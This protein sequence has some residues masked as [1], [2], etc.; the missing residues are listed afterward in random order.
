MYPHNRQLVSIMRLQFKTQHLALL[1]ILV[2][3]LLLRLALW[4]RLPRTGMISDE[5][6]YLAAADWLANGR[7]FAWHLGWLW[8]RAPLYPIFIATHLVAFGQN[9]APIFV[10]Q[11]LLSLLNIGLVYLLAGQLQPTSNNARWI[12]ALLAALYLP[13]A[14]YT[15]LLLSETLFTTLMLVAFVLLGWGM[16]RFALTGQDGG[17]PVMGQDTAGCVPTVRLRPLTIVFLVL[18]GVFF[19]L[20]TLTRGLMLGFLPLVGLWLGWLVWQRSRRWGPALLVAACLLL[21]AALII[22]PWTL[23]ASRVYGGLVIVDTTG[24]FNLLLGARTAFDGGRNDEPV[25]SFVQALLDPQLT[26]EQRE[27]LLGERR[28]RDGDLL[29]RGACLYERRDPTLL[30]ALQHDVASITQAERQRLMTA[31]AL[32]LL[33]ATPGAFASKSLI[34]LIDL[35]QIN[36]TGD[37]RLASGFALGRL[38]A[39]YALSLFL[40]DDT[41]YV[42]VLPLAVLGWALMGLQH[43]GSLYSPARAIGYLLGLWLLYNLAT[44]P[45]L[46]AINRFRVPLMPFV[47]VFAAYA[48]AMLPTGGW[49]GLRSRYGLACGL[50]AGLLGLIALSPHAYLEPLRPGEGSR[51][52][53]YLGPYPS[54]LAATSLALRSR[55]AYQREQELAAALAQRDPTLAGAA[56]AAPE[57]PSYAAALGGPLL[58]GLRGAPAAGLERLATQ[59]VQPLE[60][61]QR[62]LV[63]G[64]LLRQMGQIEAARAEFGPTEVDI[65]NP[66]EWAWQ[67]LAPPPLA[68]NRLE[69]AEDNDLGYLRGFYLGRFDPDLQATLRWATDGAQLRFP[70]AGSGTPQQL[71]LHLTGLGW[72]GDL[73]MPAVRVFAGEALLGT[74]QL[75]AQLVTHCLDLPA[76]PAGSEVVTLRAPTF[77]PP[78]ADLLA[79]QGPQ[80]GQLRRLA[81]QL[82]WAAIQ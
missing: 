12:A 2:V 52:A 70:A 67:W 64:E 10:S 61:W 51:L 28:G 18:A 15:Q 80:V 34:E 35:F 46:F 57:L 8:T 24:A 69:V 36:Y 54:S 50:L 59:I 53:S 49:R 76:T 31:E 42:F 5:A 55:P 19:G 37:E 71:C 44:A 3:A 39:W 23:Y 78:A 26:V 60:D 13:F 30:A 77:V 29:R 38:P 68:N 66:V 22:A 62:S 7:G 14:T 79:Q 65:E 81:L 16:G 56:M 45:L 1:L 40:L 11:T 20:A 63:A 73:R 6:E 72:P 74:L 9:L 48:L 58:D 32:C 33:R 43:Q 47:F 41:L 25:R 17:G 82:D 4:D 75:T 21:P 27:T